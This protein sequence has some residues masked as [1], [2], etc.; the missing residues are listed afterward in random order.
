MPKILAK[1]V[2]RIC[3]RLYSEDLDLIDEL[4]A[5]AGEKRDVFLR[6][7][8]H[9]YCTHAADKLRRRIDEME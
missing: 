2:T 1:P 3:T 4:A 7:I 8:V 6:N 9:T 5:S